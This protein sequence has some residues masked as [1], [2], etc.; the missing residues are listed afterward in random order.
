M[1]DLEVL[2][3]IKCQRLYVPA[4]EVSEFIR[5]M[6]EETDLESISSEVNFG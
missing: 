5:F 1:T 2:E 6:V 3:I 4:G